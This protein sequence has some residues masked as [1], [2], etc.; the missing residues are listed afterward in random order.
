MR[1]TWV[2]RHNLLQKHLMPS[3]VE[4]KTL[5]KVGVVLALC[6]CDPKNPLYDFVWDLA[7]IL[8]KIKIIILK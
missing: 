1:T 5:K 6:P 3:V 2:A 7:A 8:K 4:D